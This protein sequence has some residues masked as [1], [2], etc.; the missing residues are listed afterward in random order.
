M[1]DKGLLDQSVRSEWSVNQSATQHTAQDTLR[2]SNTESNEQEFGG[3]GG[4]AVRVE[5]ETLE[6]GMGLGETQ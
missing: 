2:M 5:L 1:G 3:A 4:G 6:V